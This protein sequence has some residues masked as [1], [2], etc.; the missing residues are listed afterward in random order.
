MEPRVT[1]V[2]AALTILGLPPHADRDAVH[3]AY[4]QLARRTH[5]DVS[6]QAEAAT[7]FDRLTAAYR[8]AYDAAPLP[9]APR[10]TPGH[11]APPDT[12]PSLWRQPDII[13]GPGRVRPLPRPGVS[14]DDGRAR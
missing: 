5:P 13:A 10:R 8:L 14:S 7:R 6:S 1:T 4:R 11:Q 12:A 3:R 9:G 2:R